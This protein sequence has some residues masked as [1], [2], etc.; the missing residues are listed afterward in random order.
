M[1][2]ARITQLKINEPRDPSMDKGNKIIQLAVQSIM[3]SLGDSKLKF[4]KI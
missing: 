2:L 1:H 3:I 4:K